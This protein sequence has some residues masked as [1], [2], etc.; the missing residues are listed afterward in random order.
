MMYCGG[1]CNFGQ[2]MKSSY[3]LESIMSLRVIITMYLQQLMHWDF[4]VSNVSSL[5]NN[6]PTSYHICCKQ[7][8]I[9]YLPT[10][11]TITLTSIKCILCQLE[12]NISILCKTQS[13]Y[14]L[15][16]TVTET[17]KIKNKQQATLRPR[18]GAEIL[19]KE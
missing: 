13:F 12:Y 1:L 4:I 6:P 5:G 19:I 8:K 3:H 9:K 15:M 16:H 17:C 11:R 2:W 7:T 18:N 14:N 10:I